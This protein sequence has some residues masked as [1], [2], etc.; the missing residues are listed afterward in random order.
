MVLKEVNGVKFLQFEHFINS[1]LVTHCVSTRVGG[2]SDG[3]YDSLN[4]GYSRGDLEENVNKNYELLASAVGFDRNQVVFTHQVHGTN[5]LNIESVDDKSKVKDVD[6]LITNKRGIVLTTFCADCTPIFY[7]DTVKKVIATAHAG[8]RGTI[9]AIAAKTLQEMTRI[10]GSEPKDILI[11]IAPSIG[12]CC[13]EIDY[14]EAKLF[15]DNDVSKEFVL[16]DN[17]T[18]KYHVDLWGLNKKFLMDCGVPE[19]NFEVTSHCT[20][21]HSDLFYSHRTSG[22]NRGSMATFMVID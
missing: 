10:Y 12:K 18:N 14:D 15:L 20:K 16:H 5:V 19:E 22:T 11:G 6:A 13:F 4:L 8:W 17:A 9:D 3:V 1:K 7:L 21:C 2:V